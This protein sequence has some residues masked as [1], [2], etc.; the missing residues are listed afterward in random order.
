MKIKRDVWINVIERN[1]GIKVSNLK[2]ATSGNYIAYVY[3]Y[4]G[5]IIGLWNTGEGFLYGIVEVRL[6]N[7]NYEVKEILGEE[8]V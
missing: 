6:L 2:Y 3:S 4:N 1:Y 8:L 5:E 7:D